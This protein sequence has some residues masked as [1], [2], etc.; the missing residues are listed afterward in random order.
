[1][2][3]NENM[4][5][6]THAHYD[7]EA[8]EIDREEVLNLLKNNNVCGIINAG[9]DIKSSEKV[10]ELAKKWD[11]IYPA[12]GIHPENLDDFCDCEDLIS[13]LRNLILNNKNVI[14][15]G[16]IGLDYH[17]RNDNKELQK[18]IFENQIKLANELGLPITVHDR[19]AHADTKQILKKYCPKGVVH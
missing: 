10:L 17:F 9:T 11:F 4:I 2:V 1:M 16:E 3:L 19:E 12:L 18:H 13:K 7:D 5:F 6:D 15:V 8:F 14:A